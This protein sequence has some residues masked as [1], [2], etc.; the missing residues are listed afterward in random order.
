M[1]LLIVLILGVVLSPSSFGQTIEVDT[2]GGWPTGDGFKNTTTIGIDVFKNIPFL[3]LSGVPLLWDRPSAR[4]HTRGT[5]ELVFRNGNERK[6]YRTGMVG[7]ARAVVDDPKGI[8]RHQDITGWYGKGGYEWASGGR[9]AR[10]MFGI[11]GIATYCRYTTDLR[12]KGP[13]FG[14]YEGSNIINNVG[15][16]FEPYYALDL[17]LGARGMI[18]WETRWSHHFRIIGR[19][20]TPYYPG[21]GLSL[22]FY[23]YVVSGG[24]TLQLHYR[25]Q[26]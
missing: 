26:R 5:V 20:F 8:E 2:L 16:G 24:T 22:G 15:L 18:R 1:R 12:F 14:D 9:K 19:G 13:T 3:L 21:V 6:G 10:S 17:P 25:L 7:Y 4:V 11:R 23:N